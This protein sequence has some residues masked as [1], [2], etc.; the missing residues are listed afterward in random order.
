MGA[1]NNKLLE[2]DDV[3]KFLNAKKTLVEDKVCQWCRQRV[4][5]SNDG[6]TV[7]VLNWRLTEM[8]FLDM[9][10]MITYF[11]QLRLTCVTVGVR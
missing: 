9:V 8:I 4:D 10:D 5:L 6:T 3:K 1:I 7:Q 11:M 2:R